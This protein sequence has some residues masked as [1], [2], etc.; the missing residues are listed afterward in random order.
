MQRAAVSSA[1]CCVGRCRGMHEAHW[2]TL[3][4]PGNFEG[5]DRCRLRPLQA[6]IAAL[7]AGVAGHQM[8]ALL[9]A[10]QGSS[11]DAA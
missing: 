9:W 4:Q 11:A 6:R 10:L 5:G 2:A 1:W 7:A 8:P 3:D